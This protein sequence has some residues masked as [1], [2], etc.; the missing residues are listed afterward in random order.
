MKVTL[1]KPIPV[2]EKESTEVTLRCPTMDEVLAAG[3]F[4]PANDA[5]SNAHNQRTLSNLVR[6]ALRGVDGQNISD[7]TLKN[8]PISVGLTLRDALEELVG[9][10]FAL[11][12]EHREGETKSE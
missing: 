11:A 12:R 9:K 3:D 2:N 10:E 8:L 4:V 1:P 5:D 6:A 7:I